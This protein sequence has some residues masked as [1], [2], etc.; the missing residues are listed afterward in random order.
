MQRGIY[1]CFSFVCNQKPTPSTSN[2]QE[3]DTA[4]NAPTVKSTPIQ[5]ST[6]SDE[7][8][9]LWEDELENVQPPTMDRSNLS[10][11][12]GVSDLSGSM[13]SQSSRELQKIELTSEDEPTIDEI[14]DLLNGLYVGDILPARVSEANNPLKFWIHIRQEKYTV[15]INEMYKE[16][17]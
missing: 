12:Y 3:T 9:D 4:T 14:P 13:T 6:V 15:P 17:Q 10:S 1:I 16:M 2:R 5:V 11:F 8:E 7:F